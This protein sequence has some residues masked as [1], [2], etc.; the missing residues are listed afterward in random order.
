MDARLDSVIIFAKYRKKSVEQALGPGMCKGGSKKR[1][2]PVKRRSRQ[3]K[4]RPGPRQPLNAHAR[5]FADLTLLVTFPEIWQLRHLETSGRT[6]L[7]TLPRIRSMLPNLS[8]GA[9]R[10]LP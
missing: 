9:L 5:L 4:I 3:L 2:Y 7:S 1:I 6:R 10:V 8:S